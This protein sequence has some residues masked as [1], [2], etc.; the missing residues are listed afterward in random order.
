M[1]GLEEGLDLVI[2]IEVDWVLGKEVLASLE[3]EVVDNESDLD[4]SV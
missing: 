3:L 4:S 2:S 1:V